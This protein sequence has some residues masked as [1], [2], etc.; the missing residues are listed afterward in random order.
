MHLRVCPHEM[1]DS[2]QPETAIKDFSVWVGRALA[3][4]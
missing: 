4:S 2:I 1:L 3:Q